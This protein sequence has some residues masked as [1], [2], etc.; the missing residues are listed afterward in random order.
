M[1]AGFEE[2][3]GGSTSAAA[4][5][6]IDSST[7]EILVAERNSAWDEV[8]DLDISPDVIVHPRQDLIRAK[9]THCLD[10]GLA[11]A[12]MVRG[13]GQADLQVMW[14]RLADHR[15][16]ETIVPVW[17][18][19]TLIE[20]TGPM[21]VVDL[22]GGRG[23]APTAV[24]AV[25]QTFIDL[26]L[27]GDGSAVPNLSAL[28]SDD[29]VPLS[30]LRD[31]VVTVH[32][33]TDWE[34]FFAS[35]AET[36]TSGA[37]SFGSAFVLRG[38]PYIRDYRYAQTP[39]GQTVGVWTYRPASAEEITSSPELAESRIR[40][41]QSAI[42]DLPRP[43][44][45]HRP[46][47]DGDDIVDL[48]L[49]WSNKNFDGYRVEPAVPGDLASVNRLRFTEDFLPYIRHAWSD[50]V[51]TQFF[52]FEADDA[53]EELYRHHGVYFDG[54]LEIETLFVRTDDGFILEW[55]DDVDS[56]VRLGSDMEAQRRA[57]IEVAS[58]TNAALAKRSE[59]D[60]LSREL[61]DNILQELFVL[62]LKISGAR[63]TPENVTESTL[64]DF[65][66]T[67][68]RVTVDIRALITD[69]KTV[70][71]APINEQLASLCDDWRK[72]T[73]GDPKITF[74][75][76]MT[77]DASHLDRIN[78]DVVKN[79]V[80]IAKEAVANAVKH[81]HGTLVEVELI[82]SPA[83]LLMTVRDNGDGVDPR[84]TRSSGTLNM[85]ARAA[86]IGGDLA[87]ES[88]SDGVTVELRVPF[89][90][91]LV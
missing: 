56:K 27:D 63:G 83:Q 70:E 46:V 37:E 77:V 34:S 86:S 48:E 9:V 44:A 73:A 4:V 2:F 91:E 21:M 59:H 5:L 10:N 47:F 8:F 23:S 67:V 17:L 54:V 89:S 45:A 65:R 79:T 53:T 38:Q 16:L 49:I 87:F 26:F 6:T 75:E 28:G 81:S 78:S 40:I 30:T 19:S 18:L 7:G 35:V 1:S 72:T 36:Y 85:Q 22:P 12:W 61:H 24:A 52:R 64:D 25:N 71:G 90:L 33:D 51:A 69:S 29:Q 88:S 84:N 13:G 14:R 3:F 58:E 42:E 11:A 31:L 20:V 82:V 39:E 43:V 55:G 76:M 57:A 50:G 60:R 74:D 32:P 80:K 15:I 68:K 62:G 41:L 66:D